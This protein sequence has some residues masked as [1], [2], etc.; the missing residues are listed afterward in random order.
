VVFCRRRGISLESRNGGAGAQVRGLRCCSC[1]PDIQR[2]GAKPNAMRASRPH[3]TSICHCPP[4]TPRCAQA[5]VGGAAE[6]S[7]RV[8]SGNTPLP[9][10]K[11]RQERDHV[12]R[13]SVTVSFGHNASG[14]MR[15]RLRNVLWHPLDD[16][17]GRTPS[18]S[19]RSPRSARCRPYPPFQ[20]SGA[21]SGE[22]IHDRTSSGEPL[23]THAGILPGAMVSSAPQRPPWGR[24][25]RR[26]RQPRRRPHPFQPKRQRSKPCPTTPRSTRSG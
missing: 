26:A 1:G 17:T 10:A 13:G 15:R 19:R 22:C 2:F 20:E 12:G 8:Y 7:A 25:R 21:H 3:T 11:A 16:C 14:R 23:K 18:H 6:S 5:P 24:H 4:E 9:N